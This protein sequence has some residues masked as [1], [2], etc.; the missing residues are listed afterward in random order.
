MTQ[1]E[2]SKGISLDSAEY[3]ERNIEE[4]NFKE[5]VLRLG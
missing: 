5:K 4:Q 1:P 3:K 2:E